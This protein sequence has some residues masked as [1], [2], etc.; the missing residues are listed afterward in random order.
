MPTQSVHTGHWRTVLPSVTGQSP[1]VI[2][3]KFPSASTSASQKGS[4]SLTPEQELVSEIPT[5][6]VNTGQWRTLLPEEHRQSP[7]SICGT[8]PSASTPASHE[9]QAPF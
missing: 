4:I 7:A 1:A 9:G 2:S 5:Q 8:C 3:G 6:S